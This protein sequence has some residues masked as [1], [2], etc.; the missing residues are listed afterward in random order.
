M[1]LVYNDWYSALTNP[2]RT[3]ST[4][5]LLLG[6]W[7]LL[8]T[9]VNVT[10]GAY[11]PGFKALW[12]GFLSNGSLG[13]VYTEHDG[14]SILVDDIVF[15]IL[16]IV[17]ITLGHLGMN[18]AVEGGTISAIKELQSCM[19]GLFSGEDGIRKSIADWMIAFAIVFY[20]AWSAQYNTWVD[21]GV[22]AVSVIPFM[23]G[24]GLNVLDKAES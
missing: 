1:S 24:I 16:G 3:V 19:S 10:I 23:F 11:S 22:F 20:L 21:P 5:M 18:N 2:S 12:L 13:D 7:V 15:G 4:G 6:G 17:L 8:L 9:I 14:I